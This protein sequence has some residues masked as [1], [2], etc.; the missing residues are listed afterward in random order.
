[1]D[2]AA[3]ANG[4]RGDFFNVYGMTFSAGNT[5]NQEQLN[6]RAQ[7]MVLESNTRRPLFPHQADVVGEELLVG[8]MAARVLGVA[9][10]KQSVV[11]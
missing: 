7:V 2:V 3:S 10:E 6:G 11:G 9:A 1:V 5:F 8:N 4:V